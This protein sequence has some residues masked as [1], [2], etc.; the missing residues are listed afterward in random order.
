VT[1]WVTGDP[2]VLTLNLSGK[3]AFNLDPP[4]AMTR[5][6]RVPQELRLDAGK[7][8]TFPVKQLKSGERG[9]THYSYWTGPGEYDLTATLRTGVQP[10]PKGAKNIDGFGAVTVTSAPFRL[11]VEGR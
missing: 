11:T 10:A 6:F 9:L 5:E 4:I 1:V 8:H 7:S 2:V 3:G